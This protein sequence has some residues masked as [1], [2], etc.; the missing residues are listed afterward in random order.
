LR[1]AAASLKDS[2]RAGN[3][4]AVSAT[5]GTLSSADAAASLPVSTASGSPPAWAA[6]LRRRQAM[7]QGATMAAHTMRAGD[8]GGA[9]AGASVDVGQ[10]D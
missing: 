9:G 10:R 2:F 8:G 4:A 6:T 5:G 3:R 7:T 1:K